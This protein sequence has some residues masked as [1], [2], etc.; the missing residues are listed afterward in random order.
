MRTLLCSVQ[1]NNRRTKTNINTGKGMK[2]NTDKVVTI[3]EH[4]KDSI[5]DIQE[6]IIMDPNQ[7]IIMDSNTWEA[8]TEK[9]MDLTTSIVASFKRGIL[10][11]TTKL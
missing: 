6:E 3:L 5:R 1:E 9:K 2:V 11:A 8:R 10:R 4:L 7:S